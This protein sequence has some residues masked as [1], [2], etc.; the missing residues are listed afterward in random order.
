M[1]RPIPLRRRRLRPARADDLGVRRALAGPLLPFLVAAMAFLAALALAGMVAAASL[2]QHWRGSGTAMLT[3]QVPDPGPPAEPG[4]RVARVAALL[5]ADPDVAGVRLLSEQELQGLL[6]P[7]LGGGERDQV[8]LPLPAVLEVRMRGVASASL[9]EQLDAAAPG[10]LVDEHGPWLRRLGTLAR[11]LQDCAALATAVVAGVAAAVVAV[12]TRAGL[13]ARRDAIAVVHGLGAT[14]GYIAGRFA[15]RTTALAG[16]GGLVGTLAAVP[17]L[18]SLA[19]LAAPFATLGAGEA[20]VPGALPL[21]LW[22]CLAALPLA[23]AA[24]GWLTAQ[25]TVRSWLRRLP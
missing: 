18:A 25:G 3:V 10:T 4:S 14:D 22:L 16:M 15:R 2:A 7:W 17:L 20:S 24:I 8:A 9:A 13:S 12:A 23:A 6:R 11:S 1:S 19:Q 5:R 21:A